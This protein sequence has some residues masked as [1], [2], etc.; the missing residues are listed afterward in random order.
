VNTL[1][2]EFSEVTADQGCRF[3]V[4]HREPGELGYPGRGGWATAN[5]GGSQHLRRRYDLR[6]AQMAI[7]ST[8]GSS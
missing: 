7:C 5:G 8:Q 6:L 2:S 3:Q 1:G 4:A